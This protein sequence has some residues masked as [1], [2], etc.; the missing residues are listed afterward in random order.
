MNVMKVV[1]LKR[2]PDR[3]EQVT[4]VLTEAKVSEFDIV[5]AV[6]GKLLEPTLDMA[7]IFKGND[8]G[9]RRGVV[10][11]ALSHYN[12][13]LALIADPK[14]EYYIILEDDITVCPD[15]NKKIQCLKPVFEKEEYVLLGYHMFQRNR[16]SLKGVYETSSDTLEI[17]PLRYDLYIG[18]TFSYSINKAGAKILVDYIANNG[19]K[20]GI[21]YVVKICSELKCKELRPQM[22][23]SE[24]Y[25]IP[26][27]IVD[28]DI[29]TDIERIDFS[30]LYN[31]V[32]K[33]D[34]IQGKDHHGDDLYF[35][36][37][38]LE[39]MMEKALSD[40]NCQ[41]FNTLGFFKTRADKFESSQYF[42]NTDGIYV[43]KTIELPTFKCCKPTIKF[44]SDHYSSEGYSEAYKK[45]V[46]NIDIIPTG[47]PDYFVIV[48]KPGSGQ[49][50][51]PSKTIVLQMEPWVYD[52]SKN[53]GVKTW[54]EWAE[55]DET[56]FMHVRSHKKFLNPAEWCLNGDLSK[57]PEKQDRVS[58]ILSEKKR[59]TGHLLRYQYVSKFPKMIDVF[60][61]ANY[62]SLQNYIGQVPGDDRY[63]VYSEYKYAIAVENNSEHNYATEKIWEPLLCECLVFYWGCPNLEEY[64]DSRAFVRLPLENPE[65]A[66]EI[67][68][69]AIAEDWWS[70]RIDIIREM[71]KKVMNEFYICKIVEKVISGFN[72]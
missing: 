8:F 36:K 60:S 27:Q 3:K 59:D 26:G 1:N 30:S 22:V 11:C 42:A 71:K 4:K 34:F 58:F 55:P 39:K 19:I 47:E 21:D 20:H 7:K 53:W 40:P 28:T 62:H 46:T 68:Q 23:F 32:D 14:T 41:G 64:I 49:T 44:L 16:E 29:Q 12:L 45:K 24:W 67:I 56:K 52:N 63:N 38:S 15:F 2:R 51:D 57:L 50:Y 35:S 9:S 48:N 69:K 70:Q 65:E 66:F 72:K 6:D 33:F 37:M 17:S 54:G 5:E 18:G 43:K 10:G 25:E 61:R 13:W 31:I